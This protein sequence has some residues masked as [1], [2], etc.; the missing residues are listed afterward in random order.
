MIKCPGR[1][2]GTRSATVAGRRCHGIK[3]GDRDG[4]RGGR[5]LSA[6]PGGRASVQG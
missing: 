5:S 6:V 1:G 4:E 2:D 3:R